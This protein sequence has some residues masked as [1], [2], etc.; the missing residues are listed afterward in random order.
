MENRALRDGSFQYLTRRSARPGVIHWDDEPGAICGSCQTMW[1]AQATTCSCGH[2]T[3]PAALPVSIRGTFRVERLLGAGGMSV[4]YLATDLALD[5]KVAIKTLPHLTP[6]RVLRLRRE[7]RAMAAVHHP[8]LAMIFGVE[9]WRGAPLLIAECLEGGTL[10]DR[11]RR[12]PL[13][14]ENTIEIGIVLADV[15]DQVHASGVLHRD[16]KPSNVGFTRDGVPKLLDFGIAL[17]RDPSPADGAG[18]SA[19]AGASPADARYEAAALTH[20]DHLVGTPLYLS[21]EALAGADPAPSFDLWSLS[22]LLFEAIAGQH[23]FAAPTTAQAFERIRGAAVDIRDYRK[24][25][26]PTLIAFFLSALSQDPARRPQ[27][28][29]ELRNWLRRLRTDTQNG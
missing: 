8:N 13:P 1:P 14:W 28:A 7:A 21:P 17:M 6:D 2:P 12:G 11:L 19:H 10:A 3:A 18:V 24:D 29:A 20:A 25:C 16:I 4:V 22:L 5:R 26:P 15:L 9:S 27:S 23:P